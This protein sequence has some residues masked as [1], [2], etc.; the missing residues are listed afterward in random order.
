[1]TDHINQEKIKLV[2]VSPFRAVVKVEDESDQEASA[3]D[4]FEPEINPYEN[5]QLGIQRQP[6][7][8]DIYSS[9]NQMPYGMQPLMN[10]VGMR[11]HQSPIK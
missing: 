2:S 11:D 10:E 7:N 6:I 5:E 4:E 1:M 9:P 8:N 3:D